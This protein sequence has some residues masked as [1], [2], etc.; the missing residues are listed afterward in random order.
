MFSR[1]DVSRRSARRAA[2]SRSR[3]RQIFNNVALSNAA[4]DGRGRPNVRTRHPDLNGSQSTRSLIA[5]RIFCVRREFLVRVRPRERAAHLHTQSLLHGGRVRQQEVLAV[6]PNAHQR[7]D[8]QPSVGDA[9]DRQLHFA[10]PG[11]RREQRSCVSSYAKKKNTPTAVEALERARATRKR[12]ETPVSVFD[13]GTSPRFPSPV[14]RRR[15]F[16]RHHYSY[17]RVGVKDVS[18]IVFANAGFRIFAKIGR[19]YVFAQTH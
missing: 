11:Q 5:S 1:L 10:D 13:F 18:K 2:C 14:F 15:V 6:V 12:P 4:A 9:A 7:H 8:A 16:V 19:M 3:P 17:V